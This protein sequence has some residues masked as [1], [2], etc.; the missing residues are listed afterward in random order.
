MSN[1]RTGTLGN[2]V[3][4]YGTPVA[5]DELSRERYIKRNKVSESVIP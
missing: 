5:T 1:E 4:N 2:D 3:N